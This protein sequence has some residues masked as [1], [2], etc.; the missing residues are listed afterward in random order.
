[1]AFATTQ[2]PDTRVNVRQATPV[3]TLLHTHGSIETH[4]FI[5]CRIFVR[6]KHQRLPIVAMLSRPLHR[7]RQFVHVPMPSGLYGRF[8][9][10]ANQRMRI[11]SMPIWRPMRRSHRWL[12]LSLQARHVWRKLRGECERMS[13]QSVSQRCHM[14]RRHQSL[15]M[16]MRARIHRRP[17]RDQHR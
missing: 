7:R 5:V 12:S 4:I 14:Y 9:P 8:V 1:M 6:N 13:Q 3:S 16:Q 17:L 15:L 11:K 2:L 10:N